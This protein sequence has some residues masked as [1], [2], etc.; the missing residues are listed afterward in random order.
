[1]LY[2]H[3]IGHY[4]PENIITNRFIAELDIGSD[5]EWIMERVGIQSRRTSLSLDYIRDTRN[6]DVREASEASIISRPVASAKAAR[7]AFERAHL[8]PQ[9]IGMVIAGSCTPGRMI[10]AEAATIAAE[11]EIEAPCVDINSAC[12]T[13]VVQLAFLAGMAQ[14]SLPNFVLVVNPETFTHAVDY[15]DRSVA[16]LFGDG[17]S[18]A[19]VSNLIPSSISF[20]GFSYTSAPALWEKVVIAP[21]GHFNQDGK[22]V[23]RYAIRTVTQAIQTIQNECGREADGLKFIGHQANFLM[24][25]HVCEKCGISTENHWYNVVDFGNTG[26]SGAPIVLSQNFERL[27]NGDHVAMAVVGSGLTSAHTLVRVH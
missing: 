23:Q 15:S 8:T 10:P 20:E 6:R 18:A 2:L 7:M 25:A 22:S 24:L 5:E 9:D 19:V 3:G 27:K 11:L 21:Y 14:G 13:F 17:F 1:M 4:H 12:S 16:P 26:S